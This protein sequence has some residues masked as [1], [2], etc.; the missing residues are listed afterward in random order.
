MLLFQCA[1]GLL[2]RANVG[3]SL[4]E[5]DYR[6]WNGRSLIVERCEGTLVDGNAVETPTSQARLLYQPSHVYWHARANDALQIIHRV[7]DWHPHA[8]RTQLERQERCYLPMLLHDRNPGI[9]SVP[10]NCLDV[11]K[12]HKWTKSLWRRILEPPPQRRLNSAQVTWPDNRYP[13]WKPF[14]VTAGV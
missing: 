8:V 4:R 1:A 6:A 2:P 13:H 12:R 11:R 9:G 5:V 14:H 3:R 7:T 10:T